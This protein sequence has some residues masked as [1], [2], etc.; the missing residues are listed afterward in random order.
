V[1]VKGLILAGTVGLGVVTLLY[2]L[3]A[4]LA[5][6]KPLASWCLAGDFNIAILRACNVLPFGRTL[7]TNFDCFSVVHTKQAHEIFV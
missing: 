3:T 7:I 4:G 6:D 1:A 2:A 5:D